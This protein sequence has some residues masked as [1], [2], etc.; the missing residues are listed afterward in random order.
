MPATLIVQMPTRRNT[1]PIILERALD[2][3]CPN[4]SS[5]LPPASPTSDE[6]VHEKFTAVT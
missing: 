1:D 6:V 5:G 3:V 4:I 2:V